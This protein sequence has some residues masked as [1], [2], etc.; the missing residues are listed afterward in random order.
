MPLK[1]PVKGDPKR[2]G[3]K[4]VAKEV[5]PLKDEYLYPEPRKLQVATAVPEETIAEA[6]RKNRGLA[7]L[8]GKSIGMCG[9]QVCYRIKQ[10][11]YLQAVRDSCNELRIDVA[12]QKID[13]L[14]EDKN[15]SSLIFFLK[16]RAKNRGY[17]ETSELRVSPEVEQQLDKMLEQ[18]KFMQEKEKQD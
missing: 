4:V 13:E 5:K 17:V 8:A 10:S 16:T 12:E 14:I 2:K 15:V 1:N 6:L 9:S 7:Y 11:P 3:R 18:I